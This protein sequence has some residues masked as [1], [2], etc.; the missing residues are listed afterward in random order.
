[1]VSRSDSILGCC[2]CWY[3]GCT[4]DQVMDVFRRL[5]IPT[6]D[7]TTVLVVLVGLAIFVLLTFELWVSH[8]PGH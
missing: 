2:L 6:P 4:V 5:R 1:M 8:G 3:S 7:F